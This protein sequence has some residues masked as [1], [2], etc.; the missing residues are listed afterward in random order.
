MISESLFF[1]VYLSFRPFLG[2]KYYC[3]ARVSVYLGVCQ[4]N[5]SV[6]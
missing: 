6:V 5:L 3:F 4:L 2:A 1:M